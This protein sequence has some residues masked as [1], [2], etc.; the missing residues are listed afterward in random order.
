MFAL[1]EQERG[2]NMLFHEFKISENKSVKLRLTSRGTVGL[3][4][5]LGKS[6]IAALMENQQIPT[7]GSAI[8]ILHAALQPYEH[9]Y[10]E[11]KAYDL[12]DEYVD[13][14]GEL[15]GLIMALVEVFKVSGFFKEVPQMEEQK[16]PAKK[17]AKK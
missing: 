12:Y 2:T 1:K 7:L 14:G 16:A 4:D 15:S 10:T 6:P 3:E 8:T 11:D 17:T 9:G 13:A 5:K